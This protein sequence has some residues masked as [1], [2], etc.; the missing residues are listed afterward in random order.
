MSLRAEIPAG[1]P[2]DGEATLALPFEPWRARFFLRIPPQYVKAR[3]WP[4]LVYFYGRGRSHRDVK[5]RA[6]LRPLFDL[7]LERGFI[8]LSPDLGPDHWMGVEAEKKT[9]TTIEFALDVLSVD[10]RRIHL[11][12]ASMGG[13][14]ALVFAA[15]HSD[16]VAS[17]CSVMGATDYE[18]L[19]REEAF[20]D[21]IERALGGRPGEIP[22]VYRARSPTHNVE[23]LRQVPVLLI[24]GSK[25][26]VIP[27]GHSR[28]LYE[29]L[30]RA[31][32]LVTYKEIPGV[33]HTIRI[34]K[35]LEAEIL[36]FFA[37]NPKK[38]RL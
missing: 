6:E 27:P 9:R 8:V 22:K 24:H 37:E 33:G 25:D 15:L 11:L 38:E 2:T 14:S 3:R 36:D 21:S 13:L 32:G 4:L 26:E 28:R 12:G 17:V 35:G 10:E 23:K 19:H 1:V 34:F 18:A 30:S 5:E 7:A 20:R 29:A 31:G 16:L